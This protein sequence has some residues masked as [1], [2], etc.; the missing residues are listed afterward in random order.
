MRNPN[1][2]KQPCFA[3]P[4]LQ[5]S[6]FGNSYPVKVNTLKISTQ[7]PSLA[8][9]DSLNETISPMRPYTRR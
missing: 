3:V 4:S 7:Q 2:A 1:A 8:E 9:S 6:V 5:N